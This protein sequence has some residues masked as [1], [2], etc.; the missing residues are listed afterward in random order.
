MKRVVREV[1]KIKTMEGKERQG[2]GEGRSAWQH[3]TMWHEQRLWLYVYGGLVAASDGRYVT[4]RY[5]T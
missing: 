5:H 2:V 1:V 3:S 4:H